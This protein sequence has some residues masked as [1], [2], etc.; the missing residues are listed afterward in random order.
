MKK[1]MLAGLAGSMLLLGGVADAQQHPNLL[2]AEDL[3]ARA[4]Q[5]VNLAQHANEFDM[6]GHAQKAKELLEAAVNEI[7][8][9]NLAAD[10]HHK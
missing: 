8:L 6:G 9:A 2:I 4:F 5:R 3:A 10:Q 7:K 1:L